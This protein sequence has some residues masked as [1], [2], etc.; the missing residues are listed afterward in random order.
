[1][2]SS[3]LKECLS[4]FRSNCREAISIGKVE[5]LRTSSK[6]TEWRIRVNVMLV[7]W[8]WKPGV[9]FEFAKFQDSEFQ[10]VFESTVELAFNVV[11]LRDTHHSMQLITMILKG[12]R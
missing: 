8:D 11:V 12:T 1:M 3:H 10:R 5:I 4:L 6:S 9:D 7:Q 2:R